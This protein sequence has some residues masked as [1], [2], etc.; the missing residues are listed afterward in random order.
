VLDCAFETDPKPKGT[1][2]VRTYGGNPVPYHPSVAARDQNTTGRPRLAL[3]TASL[4]ALIRLYVKRIIGN[5]T[6]NI[7]S[8]PSRSQK[9]AMTSEAQGLGGNHT[10]A[11]KRFI[12]LTSNDASRTVLHL[13]TVDEIA[14][15]K[16]P[17]PCPPPP[18][19]SG[20]IIV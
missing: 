7:N 18:A 3:M 9:K 1:L 2:D 13:Q 20:Q 11:T 6:H 4:R 8:I 14:P 5:T 17:I 10:T 15:E 19:L 16:F 12:T